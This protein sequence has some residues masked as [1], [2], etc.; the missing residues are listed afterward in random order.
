MNSELEQ[1]KRK[2][3][4]LPRG[5]SGRRV[6]SKRLKKEIVSVINCYSITLKDA[7]LN[8][9]ITINSLQRWQNQF[10]YTCQDG[11]S[12]FNEVRVVK[13]STK[14]SHIV[15]TEKV[16]LKSSNGM[17]VE[18]SINCICEILR[19]LNATNS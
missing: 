1:L 19:R 10:G 16:L 3:G 14:D 6:F 11:G 5:T 15:S 8:L 12:N 2:I 13:S 18:G 9:G 7:E 17:T 4:K